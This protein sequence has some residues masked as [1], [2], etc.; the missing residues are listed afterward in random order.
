M[1]HKT[2]LKVFDQSSRLALAVPDKAR[3]S[4]KD[5]VC[6][7]PQFGGKLEKMSNVMSS[8]L[9][10][11]GKI[12]PSFVLPPE[13]CPSE[14]ASISIVSRNICAGVSRGDTC[15]M[16]VEGKTG[17]VGTTEE[18]LHWEGCTSLPETARCGPNGEDVGPASGRFWAVLG[19]LRGMGSTGLP[20][21]NI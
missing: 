11:I 12:T 1:K 7:S 10:I 19:C 4:H 6:I 14:Y 2:N 20:T 8:T 17:Q 15:R 16:S 9:I 5:Y 18:R 21:V 3:K 13:N